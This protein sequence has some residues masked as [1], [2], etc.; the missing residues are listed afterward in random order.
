VTALG[1]ENPRSA[2][3]AAIRSRIA[4]SGTRRQRFGSEWRC[5]SARGLL[6]G[7]ESLSPRPLRGRQGHHCHH[8][9]G[10]PPGHHLR[11][12]PVPPDTQVD[13]WRRQ[14]LR[15]MEPACTTGATTLDPVIE[16]VSGS[17]EFG[18]HRRHHDLGAHAVRSVSGHA[19]PA[20]ARNLSGTGPCS[21]SS[22]EASSSRRSNSNR[23]VT[24][25]TYWLNS[26]RPT[27]CARLRPVHRA[28][29][30]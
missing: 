6:F 18:S 3:P 23:R 10:R 20:S 15:L 29:R 5:E 22:N 13:P 9:A 25:V 24:A 12:R 27:R 21:A 30:R 11:H 4:V 2:R 14:R 19:A 17:P 7:A 26:P 8:P 28:W 1:T 16:F